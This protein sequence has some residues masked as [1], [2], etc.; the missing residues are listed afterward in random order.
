M[1]QSVA[2]EGNCG[3]VHVDKTIR[4][5]KCSGAQRF[6]AAHS[7]GRSRSGSIPCIRTMPWKSSSWDSSDD[8]LTS[9]T[10]FVVLVLLLSSSI[11][12]E[13][14]VLFLVELEGDEALVVSVA[15][16]ITSS[17]VASVS[18]TALSSSGVSDWLLSGDSPWRTKRDAVLPS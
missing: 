4:W 14:S 17:P 13:D 3:A 16:T 11:C 8:L 18:D 6:L 12:K 1:N 2:P 5:I 7:R 15:P 10:A 9:S